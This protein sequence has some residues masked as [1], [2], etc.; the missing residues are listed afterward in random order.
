MDELRATPFSTG[1][2]RLLADT[3]EDG[4]R[5]IWQG[6]PDGVA[7]M[8]MWRF[9]WWV[10][11]LWLLATIIALA[12]GWIGVSARP[13]LMVGAAMLAAPFVL[14]LHDLQTLFAI[15]NRRALILRT[16][17]GRR[18]FR[19]TS[20]PAMDRE[21]EILD[22]GRGAGH[23]NFASGVSTRSPDTDYTGRYGF[24]C[25]RDPVRI[26]DILERARARKAPARARGKAS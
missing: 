1:L 7:H 3:L 8:M 13:L 10:G 4:E 2:R 9:L 21:F 25:V 24:R 5:V 22:I 23:L 15:T 17:W 16:A 19:A 20:F 11:G 12:N 6:Q 18:T 26:R 14:L